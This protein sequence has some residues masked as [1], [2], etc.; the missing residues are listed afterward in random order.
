MSTNEKNLFE[1]MSDFESV[2]VELERIKNLLFIFDER[3][4]K[5]VE[6]LN[7]GWQAEHFKRRYQISKSLLDTVCIQLT[8]SIQSMTE[9]TRAG[10]SIYK[11]IK[12]ATQ[13]E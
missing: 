9:T 4:T 3:M 7:D 13:T 2:E 5:D 1:I 8:N 11:S 10:Y 12:A 6:L